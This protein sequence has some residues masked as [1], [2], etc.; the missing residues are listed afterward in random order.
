MRKYLHPSNSN[1]ILLQLIASID[2]RDRSRNQSPDEEET[3][4]LQR[5]SR[6]AP[7]AGR[8]EEENGADGKENKS[9]QRDLRFMASFSSEDTTE[10]NCPGSFRPDLSL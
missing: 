6:S 8:G 3:E 4:G 1:S 9:L 5:S 10:R 2:T 7:I